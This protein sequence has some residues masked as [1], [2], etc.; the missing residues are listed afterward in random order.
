MR[1]YNSLPEQ[2]IDKGIVFKY[3]GACSAY[4]EKPQNTRFRTI[5]VLSKNLRGRTDLHG[6]EYTPNKFY[7]TES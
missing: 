1:L 6:R 7:Y 2:I 3:F 4:H 5:N